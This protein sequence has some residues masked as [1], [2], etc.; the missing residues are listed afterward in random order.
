MIGVFYYT[1]A[2]LAIKTRK[3]S[4]R[5]DDRVM[6]PVYGCPENFWESLT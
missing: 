6:R 5:K 2:I 4:Y 1:M 3:L